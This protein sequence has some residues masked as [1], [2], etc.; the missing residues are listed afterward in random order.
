MK[1]TIVLV[2]ALMLLCA[3]VF[4][5]GATSTSSTNGSW[6]IQIVGDLV[7]PTGDAA[8]AYDMGLGG[9]AM[10]GYALDSNMTLGVLSGY[11]Y[12]MYKGAPAGYSA[13]YIPIE[14]AMRY[15][16]GSGQ[17][18]PYG[19]LGVGIALGMFST[20]AIDLGFLGTWP[21]TTT[22]TTD[23]LIDPGLGVAF[24]LSEKMD[25]VLQ[26]KV[27]IIMSSGSTGLY[28]PLQVGLNFGL[29]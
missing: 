19:I 24:N 10:V 28:I 13:A 17:V 1:K 5:A 14:A 20:P 4:A 25:L 18:R 11:Q 3:N 7:I 27:S 9:E 8:S 16:F 22:T 6:N 29:N 2:F 23:L 26:G 12:L 21:A 15:N